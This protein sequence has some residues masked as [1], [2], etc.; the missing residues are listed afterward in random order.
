V[1]RSDQNPL[2]Q[3]LARGYQE[4]PHPDPDLL[5]AFAEGAL[6]PRERRKLFE[7]LA[8]CAEC[9]ELLS[10]ASEAAPETEAALKPFLVPR[11]ALPPQRIWLPWASIAA[12]LLV[13]CSAA[14]L[15]H[16]QQSSRKH[17]EVA[18]NEPAQLP[19]PALQQPS[20]LPS[21]ELKNT[22]TKPFNPPVAK[23][24]QA[25]SASELMPAAV[26]MKE[27]QNEAAKQSNFGLQSSNSFSNTQ[28]GQARAHGPS[29]QNYASAYAPSAFANAAQE[30]SSST[31]SLASAARSHWRI[32]SAGQPERS[33]GDGAWQSV[34]PQE[35]SKL[36]VVSVFGSEVWI[37]GENARL[38]HST[39]NGATWKLIT[40]PSKD[41]RSH[42]IAHIHFQTAQSGTVEAEDGTLWTTLDGGATWND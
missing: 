20:P 18:A 16:Q 34:L 33:F 14:L 26:A 3:E 32:N 15:Y 42:T 38:Y 23:P 27:N 36:R 40:L 22:L 6:L 10:I 9:R 17:A 35:Q 7:H 29:M 25:P 30:R 12:S 24:A 8:R 11:R 21:P 37:G 19:A 41:G 4:D 31:A 1:N 28:I 5:T 13:V 2:Q 39:D